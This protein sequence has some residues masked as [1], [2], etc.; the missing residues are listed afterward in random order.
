MELNKKSR[1][2]EIRK[3]LARKM[4]KEGIPA[5]LWDEC[6]NATH[7]ALKSGDGSRLAINE[8]LELGKDLQGRFGGSVNLADRARNAGL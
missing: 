1:L 2:D 7:K 5:R 3:S 4:D 6:W 8:G